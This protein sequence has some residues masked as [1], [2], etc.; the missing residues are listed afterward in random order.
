MHHSDSDSHTEQEPTVTRTAQQIVPTATTRVPVPA[1]PGAGITYLSG[2]SSQLLLDAAPRY[3]NLGLLAQPGNRIDLLGDQVAAWAVD[4][5]CFAKGASFDEAGYVAYLQRMSR[6]GTLLWA[7]APDVVGDYA[8]TTRRSLPW[9]A[10]IRQLG[11]PAAYVAQ[12][13]METDLHNVDWTRM[14]ALF[15]GGSTEWKLGAGAARCAEAALDHGL[16]VHMGRVNSLR[17]LRY[18]QSIGCD[19]ADGTYVAFGPSKNAPKV[20]EW[21]DTMAADRAAA[22]AADRAAA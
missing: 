13:G 7:T 18:A 16:H 10:T 17:R 4:N 6:A 15:I 19:T 9:L 3:R 22:A 1:M 2:A 21:L 20:L 11:V 14:D 5:G 8:A 12:D